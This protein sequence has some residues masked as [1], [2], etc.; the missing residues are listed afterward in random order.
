M[1]LIWYKEPWE[2]FEVKNFLSESELQE[3]RKY[4]SKL[5][6]PTGII[7]SGSTSRKNV[8]AAYR[9]NTEWNSE[10]T[11]SANDHMTQFLF[12]RFKQL[13]EILNSDESSN[14]SGFD[15]AKHVLHLEYDRIYP[16]FEWQIHNDLWTKQVSFILH[17][18]EYGHGTRLYQ[19]AD[20]SGTKRTVNWIPAGGGGFMR[21]D[22][23]HHSFDTLDDNTIRHTIIFTSRL[24]GVDW[25]KPPK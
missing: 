2:H 23:T 21:G 12:H 17:V 19:N 25:T 10:Q 14:Y 7:D 3:V 22:E 1:E 13:L 18:S 11:P 16:G 15:S 5:H 20:G 24:K 4:F 9:C 8:I 6:Q